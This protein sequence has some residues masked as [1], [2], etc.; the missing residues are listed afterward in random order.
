MGIIILDWINLAARGRLLSRPGLTKPN[1]TLGQR[2]E[3]LE[4]VVT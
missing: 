4:N 2:G 1:S 3:S